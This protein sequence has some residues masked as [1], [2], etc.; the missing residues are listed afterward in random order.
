MT[1]QRVI[2]VPAP[3]PYIYDAKVIKIVDGDTVK[4]E[5]TREFVYQ[6]DFGFHQQE[7]LLITRSAQETFRL[8]RINAP[9][10][11]TQAGKDAKEALTAL[12]QPVAGAWK[13]LTA[14]TLKQDKYGRWLLELYVQ[15]EGKPDMNVNDW[16]VTFKY[17]VPY[18]E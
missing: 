2:V 9:E 18:V 10:I 15:E 4:L 16:M 3:V 7:R 1:R 14:K 13:A 6:I 12:L 11:G 5:V 8:A 17:A